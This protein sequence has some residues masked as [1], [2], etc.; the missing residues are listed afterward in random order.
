MTIMIC[1]QWMMRLQKVPYVKLFLVIEREMTIML[2]A[3]TSNSYLQQRNVGVTQKNK[4]Q[5][6][7]PTFKKNVIT[8]H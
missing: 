4:I 1:D 8:Y 5:T 6:F 2:K 3:V 7:R